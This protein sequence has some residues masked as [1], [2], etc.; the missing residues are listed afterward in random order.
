[1]KRYVVIFSASFVFACELMCIFFLFTQASRTICKQKTKRGNFPD[2][3]YYSSKKLNEFYFTKEAQEEH[4]EIT[5]EL[6]PVLYNLLMQKLAITNNIDDF[7]K[8][9]EKKNDAANFLPLEDTIPAP[10]KLYVPPLESSSNLLANPD[11]N[12]KNIN[13]LIQG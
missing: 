8:K 5:V 9:K 6:M 12:A 1:M 7:D 13:D 3:S 4:A 2:G 11:P 10:S